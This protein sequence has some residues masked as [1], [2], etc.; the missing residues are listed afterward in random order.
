MSYN[1]HKPT[2]QIPFLTVYKTC[3]T[4]PTHTHT[5]T[6]KYALHFEHISRDVRL[7]CGLIPGQAWF[8]TLLIAALIVCQL[9]GC[10]IR[11]VRSQ[12]GFFSFFFSL[13]FMFAL[14]FFFLLKSAKLDWYAS[15]WEESCMPYLRDRP[16][17]ESAGTSGLRIGVRKV[18]WVYPVDFPCY[19]LH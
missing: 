16:N 10:Q 13:P 3:N 12:P 1:P 17:V 11:H 7:I 19:G 5:P 18:Q 2:H 6:Q 4:P 8:R 14:S 9:P 15:S